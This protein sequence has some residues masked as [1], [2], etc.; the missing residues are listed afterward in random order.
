MSGHEQ[1][2]QEEAMDSYPGFYATPGAMWPGAIWPGEPLLPS[3][4]PAP[5]FAFG[6]PYVSWS[7]GTPYT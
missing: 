2:P 6:V 3:A 7:T 5:D 1:D 4:G